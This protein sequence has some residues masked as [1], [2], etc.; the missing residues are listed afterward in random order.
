L[1][2]TLAFFSKNPESNYF[3]HKKLKKQSFFPKLKHLPEKF[4]FP[5]NFQTS[6]NLKLYSNFQAA[7]VAMSAGLPFLIPMCGPLS[8]AAVD[9]LA[10]QAENGV[11]K[12]SPLDAC[13]KMGMCPDC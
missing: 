7:C 4:N 10:D 2:K 1:N 13:K 5:T 3:P 6:P 8:N 11:K 9:M 12:L